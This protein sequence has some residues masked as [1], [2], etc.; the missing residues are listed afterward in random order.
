MLRRCEETKK[1]QNYHVKRNRGPCTFSKFLW[2]KYAMDQVFDGTRGLQ[3]IS[4]SV[5]PISSKK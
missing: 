4:M 3:H 5:D 2:K 1:S